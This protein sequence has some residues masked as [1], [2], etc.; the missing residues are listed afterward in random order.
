M[1]HEL[2]HKGNYLSRRDITGGHIG[3]GSYIT[4]EDV[5]LRRYITEEDIYPSSYI[6][7][8]DISPKSY[9]SDEVPRVTSEKITFYLGIKS[10]RTFVPGGS[11]E[12][13]H[14][15]YMSHK[16]H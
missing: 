11:H 7:E 4:E 9:I 2:H 6:T 3:H 14:T 12:L 13:R 10:S 15:G 5:C 8:E 16:L 1:L